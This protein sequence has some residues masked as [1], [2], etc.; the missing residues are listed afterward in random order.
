[1]WTSKPDREPVG[2]FDVLRRLK[3][4]LEINIELASPDDFIPALDGWQGRSVFIA[5]HA[6]IDFF[7]YDFYAQALAKIERDQTGT[8]AMSCK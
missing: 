4:E 6:R 2:I 7:H 1:M 3:E 8:G 5:R